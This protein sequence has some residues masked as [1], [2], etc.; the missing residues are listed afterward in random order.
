MKK[1]NLLLTISSKLFLLSFA[2]LW[3]I[4]EN[5]FWIEKSIPELPESLLLCLLLRESL[6]WGIDFFGASIINQS[7]ILMIG[8]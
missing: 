6:A 3:S 5:E 8:K 4:D 1:L 2:G 7:E